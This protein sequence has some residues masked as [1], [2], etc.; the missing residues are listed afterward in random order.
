MEKFKKNKYQYM[1]T[2]L[3]VLTMI[4]VLGIYMVEQC[5]DGK[6]MAVTSE[7]YIK[8]VDYQVSTEAMKKACRLDVESYYDDM[9]GV[10]IVT[11][12]NS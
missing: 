8:W 10:K 2:G 5:E 1:M 7:D 12:L 11:R 4:L 9:S 6:L 3:A